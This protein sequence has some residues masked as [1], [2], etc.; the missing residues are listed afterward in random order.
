V[1]DLL[2]YQSA[3]DADATIEYRDV[4]V[5]DGKAVSKRSGRVVDLLSR[6]T[7]SSS[8]RKELEAISRESRRYDLR[9]TVTGLTVNQPGIMLD[10]RDEFDVEWIGREHLSGHEVVVIDYRDKTVSRIFDKAFARNGVATTQ[11]RG[12]LWVDAT[13]AQLRQDRL[14][15]LGSVPGREKPVLLVGRISAYKESRY[16]ILV[17]ERIVYEFHERG[18]AGKNQL[19]PFFTIARTTCTFGAFRKFDVATEE[20]IE[21]PASSR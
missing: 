3:R 18:K 2:V 14:E 12:R 17:P 10:K 9:Y 4:R 8:V 13:T 5:V 21:T 20:S 15:V 1:G 16:D 11:M 6:A 19:P 7:T